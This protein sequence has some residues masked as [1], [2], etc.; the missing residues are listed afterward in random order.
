M[1]ISPKLGQLKPVIR[2]LRLLNKAWGDRNEGRGVQILHFSK[3]LINHLPSCFTETTVCTPGWSS[4]ASS[5]RQRR[6]P[7]HN[8]SHFTLPSAQRDLRWH[9]ETNCD[10][11]HFVQVL[12]RMICCQICYA[13]VLRKKEEGFVCSWEI[14]V[15]LALRKSRPLAHPLCRGFVGAVC[16]VTI[17]RPGVNLMVNCQEV[18]EEKLPNCELIRKAL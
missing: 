4:Y 8:Q 6:H 10:R 13:E 5:D 9:F 3:A 2:N 12:P 15:R 14:T 7:H 1:R 18:W 11:S 17:P 16:Q